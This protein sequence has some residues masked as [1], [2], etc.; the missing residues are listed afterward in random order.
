MPSYTRTTI[1]VLSQERVTGNET[2][3]IIESLCRH[4]ARL[5]TKDDNPNS[6]T[7]ILQVLDWEITSHRV[8]YE[9]TEQRAYLVTITAKEPMCMCKPSAIF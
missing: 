8:F 5:R 1:Q 2:F 4:G 6:P 3:F 7:T 9:N